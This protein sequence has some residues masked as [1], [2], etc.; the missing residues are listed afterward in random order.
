MGAGLVP[1]S[2]RGGFRKGRGS[3]SCAQPRA[4]PKDRMRSKSM[5]SPATTTTPPEVPVPPLAAG[6][7]LTRAEFERRYD[8]MPD[9]KKA[10]LI[11]GVVVIMPSPV[12]VFHHGVPHVRLVTWLGTYAAHTPGVQAMDNG[13]VRLDETNEPQPDATLFIERGGQTRV[14]ADDSLE[15][16][17]ELVAEVSASRLPQDTG[18]RREAYRRN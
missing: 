4:G 8:T 11:E 9:L 17:P 14:A 3:L 10:E 18:P 5:S 15:G 12:R 13:T 16:A 1:A 2:C 6:Q 7:R